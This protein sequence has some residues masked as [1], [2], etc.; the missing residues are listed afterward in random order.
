MLSEF[1]RRRKTVA[2]EFKVMSAAPGEITKLLTE[3]RLGNPGAESRLAE[4]VYGELHR[5]A[6]RKMSGERQ[7]HTLQ[8][9]ALV[10]EAFL[11]LIRAEDMEWTDRNHFFSV[12]ATLMRRILIDHARQFRALKRGGGAK[13]DLDEAMAITHE[14]S[15]ELLALDGALTELT[16]LDPRQSR[17]VELRFFAGLS[18]EEI[19]A[20]LDLSSRTVRREWRTARAWLHTRI[21]GPA[22]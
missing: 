1:N 16:A 21:A 12:A 2:L 22:A 6:K 15:D 8:P 19:A 17:I 9:T 13:I 7:D 5:L 4:L 10:N 20:L 18:E 3:T 14:H 11:R